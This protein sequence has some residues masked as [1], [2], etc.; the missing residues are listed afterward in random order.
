[1]RQYYIGWESN[2]Y[3]MKIDLLSF[4]GHFYIDYFLDWVMEVERSFEYMRILKDRKVKLMAYEFKWTAT[5]LVY[6]QGKGSM[7][8][9]LKMKLL[10]KA[11][12]LAPNFE[13]RLF[14]QYKEYRQGSQ[15]VQA[16]VNEFY[17]LFV[18][19]DLMEMKA[20]KVAR[21]VACGGGNL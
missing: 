1:M 12:F 7:T 21:I 3:R 11:W 6:R 5:D 10:L 15:T 8:S 9:S 14:Q 19:N 2:E 13:Q 20:Q 4:N 18:R 17:H 16:Y